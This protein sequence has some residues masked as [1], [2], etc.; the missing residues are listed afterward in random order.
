M[1]IF[2]MGMMSIISLHGREEDRERRGG[3]HGVLH[4]LSDGIGDE[5][6]MNEILFQL[7]DDGVCVCV[8]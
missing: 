5:G 6:G 8:M 4:I 1:S 7:Y 2:S 3:L